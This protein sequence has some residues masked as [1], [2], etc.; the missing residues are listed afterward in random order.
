MGTKYLNIDGMS[1]PDNASD[2]E[3]ALDR[4]EGVKLTVFY[5]EGLGVLKISGDVSPE[6]VTRYI[7]DKGYNVNVVDEKATKQSTDP[8]F[9]PFVLCAIACP[10]ILIFVGLGGIGILMSVITAS[11]VYFSGFVLVIVSVVFY[12]IRSRSK[13]LG[14]RH[15]GGTLNA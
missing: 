6:T 3:K 12:L 8:S 4:F 13:R 10:L 14:G 9:L 7:E 15:E 2:L 1:N 11:P 5:K